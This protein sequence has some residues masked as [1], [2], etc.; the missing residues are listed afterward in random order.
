MQPRR[1]TKSTGATVATYQPAVG[2]CKEIFIHHRRANFVGND[3][4]YIWRWEG[5][6]NAH[7]IMLLEKSDA[8][9]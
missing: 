9:E 1:D 4:V 8:F 2:E 6:G 3:G 7:K 5:I